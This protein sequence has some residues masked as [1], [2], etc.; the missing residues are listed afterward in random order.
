MNNFRRYS[1]LKGFLWTAAKRLGRMT[2][3]IRRLV[4]ERDEAL[5]QLARV[6]AYPP[7]TPYSPIPD[8]RLVRGEEDRIFGR[9]ARPRQ[10]IPGID[11]NQ[12]GQ[13]E[14]LERFAREY[15]AEAPFPATHDPRWRYYYENPM[16]GYA[17]A[18]FLYCMLRYSRPR[19]LIEVGSGFS[20]AAALDTNQAFLSGEMACTFI[21]PDTSRVESLLSAEDRERITLCRCRVQDVDTSV[22]AQLSAGDVLFVDSSHVSKVGSDV[23]FLLFE[24]LPLLAPGVY[25]HFHDICY[26]FE[27]PKEWIYSGI[28]WNEAY[29]VH[30]F[31]QYNQAFQ[32]RVWNQFLGLLVPELLA[33]KMPLCLKNIGGSLWLQKVSS[34]PATARVLSPGNGHEVS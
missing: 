10:A 6:A 32:I 13:L 8:L 9:S 31:L 23:N 22:F 19:R 14:L 7:G 3:P 2:P 25:V 24:V 20:S 29:A 5:A 11:L 34:T 1:A 18:I 12:A 28:A 4:D 33:E 21:D 17:D 27:Y 30:A 16:F 15:Y 26:P